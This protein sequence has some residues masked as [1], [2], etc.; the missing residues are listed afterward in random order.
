MSTLPDASS[1]AV[2]VERMSVIEP[3][4]AKLPAPVGS[5]S[6]ALEVAPPATRTVPEASNVAV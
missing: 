1:V 2:C 6:S 4:T 3:V 5:N